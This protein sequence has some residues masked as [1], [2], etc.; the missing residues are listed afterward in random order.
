MPEN[1]RGGF[2]STHTVHCT[3]HTHAHMQQYIVL[4]QLLL[5][6]QCMLVV[7]LVVCE[8]VTKFS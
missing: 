6:P 7:L 3:P 1:L 5:I 4:F 8:T 2:F